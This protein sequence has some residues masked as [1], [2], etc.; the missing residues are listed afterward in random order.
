MAA[1]FR[2][3]LD[4]PEMHGWKVII[5]KDAGQ[6]QISQLDTVKVPG[7]SRAACIKAQR[8][9]GELKKFSLQSQHTLIQKCPKITSI[10]KTIHLPNIIY[11]H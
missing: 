5:T 11:E 3:L 1:R 4:H 10:K 7:S 2:K 8:T 9:Q 6:V